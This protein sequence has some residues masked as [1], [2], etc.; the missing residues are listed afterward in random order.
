MN[1]E[2]ILK[3]LFCKVRKG[4]FITPL[5]HLVKRQLWNIIKPYLEDIYWKGYEH[6][7]TESQS[8]KDIEELLR[9][10]EI[11]LM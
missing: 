6:S 1:I 11:C 9:K 4:A 7:H 5:L 10:E 3:P 2:K 8:L